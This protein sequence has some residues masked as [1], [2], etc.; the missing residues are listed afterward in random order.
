MPDRSK[1][2]VFWRA[3]A[4]ADVASWRAI[5]TLKR[6]TWRGLFGGGKAE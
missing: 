6:L 3:C 5:A 2:T 4:S 1:T